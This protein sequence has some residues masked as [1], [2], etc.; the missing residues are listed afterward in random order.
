MIGT[1]KF[2]YLRRELLAAAIVPMALAACKGKEPEGPA[3]TQAPSSTTTTP[4]TPASV[5][6]TGGGVEPSTPRVVSYEEAEAVFKAGKF[7]EARKLFDVYVDSKPENVWGWYMLGL[8]AWKSGA[9]NEAE[10]AFDIAIAK[11]SQHVKSLL[12][13]A[14]VLMDLG[15]D[16]EALER[17]KAARAV[18]SASGDGIRLL[19]RAYHRLGDIPQAVET[20]R[21]ALLIDDRDVW[22][23]NNLGMLYIEQKDPNLALGPLARAVELR[24]ASPVFQ[25]N[26]GMALELT[27][28][29]T[30][31]KRHYDDAVKADSTYTRAR[32]N[33]TRLSEVTVDPATEPAIDV[34]EI[35]EVFRQQV[36]MWKD[37]IPPTQPQ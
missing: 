12:N 14:R 22:A 33:A 36:K 3:L 25:N 5:G 37:S 9:L 27:G 18:D 8:S 13:S 29:L 32:A 30:A 16:N 31:A 11:D 7:D 21:L 34:S 17:V 6:G 24:P 26:L 2:Q 35:A 4:V 23:M 28:H 19:A 20:Y 10:E 1:G 15:R